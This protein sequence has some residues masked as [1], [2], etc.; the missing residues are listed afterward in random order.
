MPIKFRCPHCRQFLGISRAKAGEVADCPMCGKTLR[1]PDLDGTV[2]PLPT[3]K[4]DLQDSSLVSALGELAGIGS[5]NATIDHGANEDH[6]EVSGD[7]DVNPTAEPVVLEPL[8]PAQPVAT[9]ARVRAKKARKRSGPVETAR[10]VRPGEATI[11]GL[12]DSLHSIPAP[13]IAIG[14]TGQPGRSHSIPWR[15]IAAILGLLLLGGI[16][17]LLMNRTTTPTVTATDA[18]VAIPAAAVS[19]DTETAAPSITGRIT[20]VSESGDTRP[21]DGAKVIA[22]PSVRSGT[23]KLDVAGFLVGSGDVDAQVATAA[24]RALGGDVTSADEQGEYSLMLNDAGA[25]QLLVISRHQS[26]TWEVGMENQV[27]ELLDRYF[28]RPSTLLGQL[29]YQLQE[30]Q[31]RGQGTSPRDFAFDR[32]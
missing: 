26:R 30:L 9:A 21:D 14:K 7:F 23:V 29:A 27:Q 24:L 10:S 32:N 22:L 3:P 15:P 25:Y 4:L 6:V 11:N 19:A 31:F 2:K 16:G 1:V 17:L 20:Y 18:E 5:D 8:E 12:E 13:P 28:I